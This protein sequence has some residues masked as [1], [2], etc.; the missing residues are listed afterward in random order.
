ME[1]SIKEAVNLDGTKEKTLRSYRIFRLEFNR[2]FRLYDNSIYAYQLARKKIYSDIDTNIINY[3]NDIS[4]VS[5]EGNE[6]K[7]SKAISFAHRMKGQYP[8]YLRELIFVRLIS[9]LETFFVD[10][11][12][13]SFKLN[14]SILKVDPTEISEISKAELLSYGTIEDALT[15]FIERE[16]RTLTNQG[17]DGIKKYYLKTLEIDFSK[18]NLDLSKLSKFHDERH[19]LVHRLGQTD[20]QYRHKYNTDKKQITINEVNLIEAL[21]LIKALVDYLNRELVEI[22]ELELKKMFTLK[23]L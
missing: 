18:S 16:C 13:E 19:L 21:T 14:K 3:E 5:F 12:K 23:L 11:I 15:R 8:R 22:V 9:A 17:Y 6:F 7:I 1:S 20:N 10:A 4:F 2:L